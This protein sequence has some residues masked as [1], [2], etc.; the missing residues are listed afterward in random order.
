LPIHTLFH[1]SSPSQEELPNVESNFT[2]TYLPSAQIGLSIKT[3]DIWQWQSQLLLSIEHPES[4][5]SPP[6]K[7]AKLES[8]VVSQMFNNIQRI[9]GSEATKSTVEN[10]LFDNYNI[11]HFTGHV[12]NNLS[13]PK[14]SELA[15]AGEDK[16]TLNEICQQNL[17][18]YNLITLSACEN[19][20]TGNHTI[21]SEYV[22]LASGFVSQGVPHIVSTL[23]SVESSA[24]ALV[25]IEFYRRLQP[26]KSAVTALAE[27]TQWLKELTAGELTKWYEDIL[28]NLHP[29]EVRIQTYLAT[30]LYR[31][32]KM[33]SDKNL[34]N[35]P[36]YWAAFT[37]TGKPN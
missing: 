12:T 14:K 35:H 13:E 29:E 22:S 3:E 10:A 21:S 11:F 19:F 1:L 20:S 15:L 27:A 6:L 37:I 30:Q 32:S 24:S 8:E 26:N 5:G 31:N 7:F 34:Y 33:S 25:M 2:V 36:Y 23:W 4:A 28:N 9:Q 18:N 16:L 17:S